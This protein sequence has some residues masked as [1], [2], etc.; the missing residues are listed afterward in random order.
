MLKLNDGH[1]SD[2]NLMLFNF[3]GFAIYFKYSYYLKNNK[4]SLDTNRLSSVFLTAKRSF[5]Y[6]TYCFSLTKCILFSC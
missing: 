3:F 6:K 4:K 1:I 5:S 2:C